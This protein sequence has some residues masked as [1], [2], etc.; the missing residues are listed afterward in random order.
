MHAARATRCGRCPGRSG[1]VGRTEE[2]EQACR[3]AVA[4]LEPLAPG[5][6]LARAY[7]ALAFLYMAASDLEQTI[8]WGTRALEVAREL[9]D[10]E[11]IVTALT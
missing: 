4:V 7:S 5:P 6:E 2:A 10:A 11:A 8:A 1:C 9:D 3:E